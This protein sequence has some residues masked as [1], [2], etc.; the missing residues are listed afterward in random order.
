MT[1]ESSFHASMVRIYERARVEADYNA[2]YF[3]RMLSEHGGVETARRLVTSTSP[4]EGFNQLW[5]RRRLDL[6]VEAH[7]L[8]PEFRSLFTK[9]ERTAARRRLEQ[10]GWTSDES[11][12]AG[13]D[14]S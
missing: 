3:L 11:A 13:R 5:E 14:D 4:S 1:T 6:T 7:V 2:T 12:A 10:Y 9:Q 8:A